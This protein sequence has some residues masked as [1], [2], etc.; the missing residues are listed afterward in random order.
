MV[1]DKRVFRTELF[2]RKTLGLGNLFGPK[3]SSETIR[4]PLW[5]LDSSSFTAWK[6]ILKMQF[7]TSTVEE[8]PLCR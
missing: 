4:L 5:Q 6:R 7:R 2:M 8:V 1:Q 3:R